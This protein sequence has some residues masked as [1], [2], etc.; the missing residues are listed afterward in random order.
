M[1]LVGLCSHPYEAGVLR[2]VRTAQKGFFVDSGLPSCYGYWFSVGT[3]LPA[4]VLRLL[5]LTPPSLPR[6][7]RRSSGRNEARRKVSEMEPL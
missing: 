5:C 7:T 1:R 4:F 3:G 2:K 6:R